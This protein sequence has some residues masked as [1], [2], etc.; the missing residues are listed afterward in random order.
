VLQKSS[1]LIAGVKDVYKKVAE[2]TEELIGVLGNTE[3]KA[4]RAALADCHRVN[5]AFDL[6]G[7]T[8]PDWPQVELAE[9]EGG[10][11]GAAQKM[12]RFELASEATDTRK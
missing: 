8:Y 9:S 7:L 3:N 10:K 4:I 1:S 6:L 12:K 5:R 2:A 11:G